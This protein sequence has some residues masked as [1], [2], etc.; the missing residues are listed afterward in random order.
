VKPLD[1]QRLKQVRRIGSIYLVSVR[2]F[3]YLREKEASQ[4]E[5]VPTCAQQLPQRPGIKAV[6]KKDRM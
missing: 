5:N 1:L 4:A 6:A 2:N 3:R